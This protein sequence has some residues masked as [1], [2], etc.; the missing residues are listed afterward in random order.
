MRIRKFAGSV[1]HPCHDSTLLFHNRPLFFLF[2]DWVDLENDKIR[3]TC[4]DDLKFFMEES[5]VQ[6]LIFDFDSRGVLESSR[7]RTSS[8]IAEDES[9]SKRIR[10]Q[11]QQIDLSSDSSAMETDDDDI[12][13]S[14]SNSASGSK[15]GS[16]SNIEQTVREETNAATNSPN[17]QVLNVEII[18]QPDQSML[19]EHTKPIEIVDDNG[20]EE[21]VVSDEVIV[22]EAVTTDENVQGSSPSEKRKAETNRIVISDS[23]DEEAPRDS[24]NNRRFSDGPSATAYAFVNG[25]G[26]ESRAGRHRHFRRGPRVHHYHSFHEQTREFE[27]RHAENMDRFHEHARRARDHATRAVRASTSVIP[28]LIS[29]FQSHFRPMFRVSDINQNIFGFARR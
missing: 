1:S 24:E 22:E 10:K 9:N 2:L 26:F 5:P 11:F 17:V 29:T 8:E 25:E 27:R 15:S 21:Q 20:N 16:D 6:K 7:K 13:V 12:S 28:D 3:I 18:Q 19:D 14:L 23:S 4:D